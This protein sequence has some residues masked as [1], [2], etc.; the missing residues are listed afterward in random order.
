MVVAELRNSGIASVH[1]F[2]DVRIGPKSQRA[3]L[4]TSLRCRIAVKS[5][6]GGVVL[7]AIDHSRPVVGANAHPPDEVAELVERGGTSQHASVSRVGAEVSER[8]LGN[9][10]IS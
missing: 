9:A 8:T 1:A 7:I 4:N 10:E 5:D 3:L 2:V 6:V